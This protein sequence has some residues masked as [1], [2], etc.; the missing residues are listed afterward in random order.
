MKLPY[1]AV[2]TL[3]LN[4][5][6]SAKKTGGDDH[7]I[8][9]L[10]AKV[11]AQDAKIANLEALHDAKIAVYDANIANLEALLLGAP[12]VP[13]GK[14][15]LRRRGLREDDATVDFATLMDF[16]TTEEKTEDMIALHGLASVLKSLIFKMAEMDPVFDCLSYDEV[17]QTCTLGSNNTNTV[18]IIAKDDIDV[19]TVSNTDSGGKF[20]S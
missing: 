17:S 18:D 19:R 7:M 12:R 9:N 8:R 14:K 5:V 15:N 4:S 11:E 10:L 2:V 1:T 6:V 3:V 16:S 13:Q 20:K